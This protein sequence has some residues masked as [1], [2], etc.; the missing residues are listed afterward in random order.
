MLRTGLCLAREAVGAD[1]VKRLSRTEFRACS[2]GSI[3]RKDKQVDPTA[4]VVQPDEI[5]V[6]GRAR[7]RPGAGRR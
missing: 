2:S 3:S 4:R 7:H 1:E 5:P 6:R